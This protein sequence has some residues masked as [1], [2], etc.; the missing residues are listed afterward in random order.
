[1]MEGSGLSTFVMPEKESQESKEPAEQSSMPELEETEIEPELWKKSELPRDEGNPADGD[2]L[3]G[4]GARDE[5]AGAGDEVRNTVRGGAG[6]GDDAGGAGDDAGAGDEAAG[7]GAGAGGGDG[8]AAKDDAGRRT[9]AEVGLEA[10]DEAAI[11]DDAGTVD[12]SFRVD[13][14]GA[15]DGV[16][17]GT[18]FFQTAHRKFPRHFFQKM[19]HVDIS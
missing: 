3:V 10:G 6:S 14:A 7:E 2:A 12:V 13:D 16:A 4:A 17:S 1:M 9:G 15:V 18:L 11:R 8:G 5:A 19:V